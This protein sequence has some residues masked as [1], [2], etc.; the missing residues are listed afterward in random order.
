[1]TVRVDA[2]IAVGEDIHALGV[3]ERGFVGSLGTQGV[4]DTRSLSSNNKFWGKVST[5]KR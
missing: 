4:I 1:M 3:A 2:I 5:K